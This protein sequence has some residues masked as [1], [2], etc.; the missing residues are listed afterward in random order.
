MAYIRIYREVMEMRKG[1]RVCSVLLTLVM[2]L[3]L[4]PAGAVSAHAEKEISPEER[5]EAIAQ[6]LVN[7]EFTENGLSIT[8]GGD[9]A[10]PKGTK[11]PLTVSGIAVIIDL[12]GHTIDRGLGA[13]TAQD[14]GSVFEVTDG[15]S[16][17]VQ[18]GSNNGGGKLCGGNTA[19]NGGGIYVESGSLTLKNVEISGNTAAEN[20]GG[21]YVESGDFTMSS[22]KICDNVA[23]GAGGG[24]YICKGTELAVHGGAIDDNSAAFGGGV[25]EDGP[26]GRFTMNGGSIDGNFA[27]TGSGV[28]VYSGLMHLAG[29]SITNNYTDN[30]ALTY[31]FAP[32]EGG[33][34]V[35]SAAGSE[36]WLSG[37]VSVDNNDGGNVVLAGLDNKSITPLKTPYI[38]EKL[39]GDSRIGV[40]KRAVSIPDK[41]EPWVLKP[42]GELDGALT[43][44]M[45]GMFVRTSF[46]SDDGF[47][48]VLNDK[49]EAE[50]VESGLRIE[51]TS[52]A[53]DR[54][55][56]VRVVNTRSQAIVLLVGAWYDKDGRL[57]G[58]SAKREVIPQQSA[59]DFKL[60]KPEG[61][62]GAA[63]CKVLI[64]GSGYEPICPEWHG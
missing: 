14:R 59:S 25:F 3:A 43:K 49:G 55:L 34:V 52:T 2:V 28:Y 18:D 50:L 10:A 38:S 61:A 15:G 1:N 4:C 9:A 37:K 64:L 23:L 30:A 7:K 54:Q 40:S 8:L 20:G 45:S 12:N 51:C 44:N 58:I 27:A 32:L 13:Q 36:L 63:S 41:N 31:A 5:W 16:L 19:G 17:T 56:N 62:K 21:V 46:F 11:L 42:E 22:G 47:A 39:D 6:M 33:L 57:A 60:D 26:D 35:N 48:V 29:G 24:I 53:A